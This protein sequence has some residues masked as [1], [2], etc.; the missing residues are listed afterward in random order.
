M[1]FLLLVGPPD[2]TAPVLSLADVNEIDVTTATGLV[3]TDEANGRLYIVVTESASNPSAAQVKAGLNH[4]GA[5]A[6]F[7]ANQAITSAGE[8]LFSITGLTTAT[9][10]YAYFMH[11]D[12]RFNQSTV[13][14]FDAWDSAT[15]NGPAAPTF[16][17]PVV[18][19]DSTPQFQIVLP[20]G[21]GDFRDAAVDDT[22]RIYTSENNEETFT[23]WATSA[24]LDA[25]QIA[26]DPISISGVTPLANGRYQ[27]H[28][29]LART[30]ALGE[31]SNQVDF[32]IDAVEAGAPVITS[33][34]VT[35]DAGADDTYI[36]DDDIQFTV[37]FDQAVDVTGTPQL[38][39]ALGGGSE[40]AGYISGT[41]TAALVFEYTVQ[42]GDDDPNGISVLANSLALNGGTINADDDATP[43]DLDH[44]AVATDSEHKVDTVVPQISAYSPMDGATG[45]LTTTNFVMTFTEDVIAGA[46]ASFRLTETGV[47]LV[48]ELD[49]TD[50]GGAL[51]IS[52][53][54]LT[55]NWTSDLSSGG[56]AY[57]IQWDAGSVTDAAANPL[58]ASSGA[59]QWNFVT[60]SAAVATWRARNAGTA[61]SNN[62]ACGPAAADRRIVICTGGRD[63]TAGTFLVTGVTVNGVA[64]TVI[65]SIQHA[66]SGGSASCSMWEILEPTGSTCDVV[67][68]HTGGTTPDG[69]YVDVYSVTGASGVA[70][71]SGTNT[72][73]PIDIT[74]TVPA[75]GCAIGTANADGG[76]LSSATVFTNLTLNADAFYFGSGTSRRAAS[77]STNSASGSTAFQ[78]D[79][80]DSPTRM[81][82]I[83]AAWAPL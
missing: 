20:D 27:A 57:D 64:A 41:G 48:E 67:V 53:N 9:T 14:S 83:V 79:N 7:A 63:G 29:R 37:T 56:T 52:G 43:A 30:G 80:V 31:L 50:F 38:T 65:Q 66:A 5:A 73:D 26:G 36:E 19:T 2:V 35:S 47:G 23:L 58:A 59:T 11:E 8:K 82:G 75:S 32:S 60:T 24:A 33:V 25:G 16:A 55:I 13:V 62:L 42:A 70:S 34:A 44:D 12:W 18:T 72:A 45:V 4:A 81:A 3:T 68:S 10:Y 22:I 74:I 28:A 17:Q 54:T 1:A 71:A 21:Y 46:A 61:T 77:G 76:T 15:V 49:E 6:V 39:F 78:I 69:V 40:V 51:V